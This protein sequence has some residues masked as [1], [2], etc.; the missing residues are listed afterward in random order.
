MS[1]FDDMEDG[2]LARLSGTRRSL[3]RS[4]GNPV[5][6]RTAVNNALCDPTIVRGSLS[7]REPKVTCPG[8]LIALSKGRTRHD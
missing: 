8:C 4:T 3:G 1:Y 2:W 6:F 7:P 5:H